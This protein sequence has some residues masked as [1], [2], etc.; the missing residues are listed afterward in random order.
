MAVFWHLLCEGSC[1][2]CKDEWD[3]HM[4]PIRK[5]CRNGICPAHLFPDIILLLLFSVAQACLTLCDPTDCS[6][7]GFP[8]HHQLPG[9]AQ[10]RVGDAIQPSHPLVSPSPPTFNLSQH[11]GLFKSQFFPSGGQRIRVSA[12]ASV[13]PMNVQDWFSSELTCLISFQCKGLSRAFFSTVLRKHH[14]LVL[15]LLDGLTF[16]SVHDYW[17]NNSFNYTDLCQQSDISAF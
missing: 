15:S 12:S 13:L 14:S 3:T 8:V 9:L 5:Q 4:K 7:P 10:T 1:G 6:T 11:Q 17:K 16:T 2:M